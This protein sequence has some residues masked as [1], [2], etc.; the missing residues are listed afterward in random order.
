M[1]RPA[2]DNVSRSRRAL[3]RAGLAAGAGLV[4]GVRLPVRAQ[5]AGPGRTGAATAAPPFA[6]NA[7]V[8]IGRD[9]TVSVVSKHL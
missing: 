5:T 8:R 1:N 9:N 4:L 7:F 3:L 6:P 2:V